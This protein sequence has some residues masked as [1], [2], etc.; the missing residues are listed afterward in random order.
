[1]QRKGYGG[2]RGLLGTKGQ[3]GSKR[4]RGLEVSQKELKRGNENFKESQ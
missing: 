2:K 1:M 3:R 4:H